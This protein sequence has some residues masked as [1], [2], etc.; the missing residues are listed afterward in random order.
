MGFANKTFA[1]KT[2]ANGWV[3]ALAAIASTGLLV[4]LG[5][6]LEPRW[7]L[8]WLAPLPVLVFALRSSAWRAGLVAFAAWLI[9]GL[10]LWG[11]LRVVGAPPIAWFANFGIIAAVFAAGVL[12]MRALARKGRLWSAWVA[13][14]AVWVTFEFV[15]NFIWPHGSG[16]ALAYS[17]LRF[18]PLLQLASLTGPWG[19]SFALMLFPA[20]LALAIY[21]WGSGQRSARREAMQVLTA[22]VGIIAAVLIFGA[23]RMSMQQAGP[24]VRVGLVASDAPGNTGVAKPGEAT[25]RIFEQYAQLAEALAA[26]GAQVVV[27]PEHVGVVVDPHLERV[28]AIFQQVADRTGATIVAGMAHVAGDWQY[29]EARIYEPGIAVQ[30]YDK[31]HLLPPYESMCTPGKSRTLLEREKK[32]GQT[33]GV[34]ICKDLDFTEP[35]RSYGRAGA[36]LMLAPA[37][38]FRVDGIWHGHIAIMRAVE[39]GFSLARSARRGLLTVTDDRGRVL[40]ETASNAAPFATLLTEVPAGHDQTLF[41]LWGD[42][43]GWCAM[44]LLVLV[45]G[46]LLMPVKSNTPSASTPLPR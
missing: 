2:S 4:F 45:L 25:E 40:A 20:G 44:V 15:R 6:G 16:G 39:D 9:G 21:C 8:M 32:A 27:L 36:G 10:N 29:N 11:Y 18:V 5:N 37:W 3:T 41:L 13:L 17:Q 28:D 43:F 34:A 14:P 24:V 12:L 26:R 1:N 42:W 23:A 19:L 35:A 33:W 30:S 22:T 31:E 38:D 46:R 7:P